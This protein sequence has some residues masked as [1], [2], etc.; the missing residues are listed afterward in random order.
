MDWKNYTVYQTQDQRAQKSKRPL[1]VIWRY[2]RK[3]SWSSSERRTPKPHISIRITGLIRNVHPRESHLGRRRISET[4]ASPERKAS[5]S[6]ETDPR[7]L[8]WRVEVR[9]APEREAGL[10]LGDLRPILPRG[11]RSGGL[12]NK[13]SPLPLAPVNLNRHPEQMENGWGFPERRGAGCVQV[14]VC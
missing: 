7:G 2:S 9:A 10:H 11:P 3:R 4:K 14:T 13:S 12:N 8:L 5:V 6:C 1:S